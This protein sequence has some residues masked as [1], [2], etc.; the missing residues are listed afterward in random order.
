MD[1]MILVVLCA[2]TISSAQSEERSGLYNSY[3][4]PDY[5]SA[6]FNPNPFLSGTGGMYPTDSLYGS[7][8]YGGY[9]VCQGVNCGTGRYCEPLTYTVSPGK[10]YRC[11]RYGDDNSFG[12]MG[13][14]GGMYP[15]GGIY[16]GMGGVTTWGTSGINGIYGQSIM[17][18]GSG[19]YP[20]YQPQPIVGGG[21]L[22][23]IVG[24]GIGMPGGAAGGIYGNYY[25]PV[26]KCFDEL[27]Y[28]VPAGSLNTDGRTRLGMPAGGACP[29]Q[30]YR[31]TE[32]T[33]GQICCNNGCGNVC[34]TP[35]TTV[36]DAANGVGVGQPGMA[37]V[38]GT[39][40][41][42]GIG[43]M[44]IIYRGLPAGNNMRMGTLPVNAT[45]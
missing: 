10:S 18:G 39:G 12:V 17:G 8:M 33:A 44:P 1:R 28:K 16:P 13:T 4:Y 23:P 20:G 11:R 14:G 25:R 6:G 30:C 24:G 27:V 2:L 31:S 3:Q 22:T 37:G 38:G 15:G 41:F 43:G 45:V 9:G 19:L 29:N 42:T 5:T 40:G 26:T 7:T 36:I 35:E 32:C 21:T 34:Y